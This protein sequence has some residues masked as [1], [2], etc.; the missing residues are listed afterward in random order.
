MKVPSEAVVVDVEVDALEADAAVEVVPTVISVSSVEIVVHLLADLVVLQVAL[1]QLHLMEEAAITRL[2]LLTPEV[3]DTEAVVEDME[4][5]VTETHQEVAAANLGGK[6]TPGLFRA[7]WCFLQS[8]FCT[9]R[10]CDFIRH[11]VF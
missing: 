7:S 6:F 9:L 3:A 4:A 2:P 11:S 8:T 10:F 5:V 1:P